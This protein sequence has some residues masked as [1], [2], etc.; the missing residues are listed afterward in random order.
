M[1][2]IEIAN[3]TNL[4]FFFRLNYVHK[5]KV[6]GKWSCIPHNYRGKVGSVR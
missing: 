4:L 6:G 5:Q 3:F 2:N 1:F